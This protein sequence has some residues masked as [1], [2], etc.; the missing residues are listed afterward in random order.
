MRMAH[1]R[2]ASEL[3]GCRALQACGRIAAT[4]K[5]TYARELQGALKHYWTLARQVR[6]RHRVRPPGR[7]CPPFRILI[8][9]KGA[10]P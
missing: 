10:L 4:S 9:T 8:S 3:E 7:W 5:L 1:R 6:F 2:A